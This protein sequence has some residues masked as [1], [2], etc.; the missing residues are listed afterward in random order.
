MRRLLIWTIG[1]TVVLMAAICAVSSVGTPNKWIPAQAKL[2]LSAGAQNAEQACWNAICPGKTTYEQAQSILQNLPILV[3][4][5]HPESPY[6]RMEWNLATS[7]PVSI[8]AYWDIPSMDIFNEVQLL[9]FPRVPALTLGDAIQW[10]GSPIATSRI[11]FIGD[12]KR[13]PAE[14]RL[15]VY[16]ANGVMLGAEGSTRHIRQEEMPSNRTLVRILPWMRV[17]SVAYV[18]A[19]L[20][21]STGNPAYQPWYGFDEIEA[22]GQC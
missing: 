12:P 14:I 15:D 1:L 7:P 6:I 21:P 3:S 19:A 20:V 2:V 16:F 22:R 4:A 8:E 5:I 18:R 10:F 17:S 13:R 11:C 9:A